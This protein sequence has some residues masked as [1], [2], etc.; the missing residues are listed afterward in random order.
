MRARL[1]DARFFWQEDQK[2]P[3]EARLDKLEGIVFHH[4]LGTVREK[5]ERIARLSRTLAQA[6]RLD[7]QHREALDRASLLCKCDLVTL[8]VGEFPE[9]QGQMGRAYAKV[10]GEPGAVS[11]AIRDHYKPVGANDDVAPDDVSATLALADRLDT[12]AGCFAVGLA[13]TGAA[14][15]FALR[16]AC[17]GTLRTLIDRG[18]GALDLPDLVGQAYDA[19]EGKRLDLSREETVAK[20]DEFASER[21]R[22]VLSGA[23]SAAVAEAVMAGT[24]PAALRDVVAAHARARALQRV[25]DAREPWLEKAKLVAKRLSG[26]SREASPRLHSLEAFASSAKR[27]DRA[28]QE[29]VRALDEATH[30]LAT[31]AAVRDALMSTQRIATELDR[32]FVETLVNDPSDP[33]TPTRLETLAHGAQAML[34]IADFSRL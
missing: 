32:I 23:A 19:F 29:L 2:A 17:I 14:D 4:R 31:E 15:P 3:L 16:R 8:M 28:I 12:I 20:F 18:Y 30:A 13:P 5:V 27:D 24:G 10:A 33:L 21:L 9:L 26:I 34:R 7:G 6:L 11:D 1:A 25:V 22:G